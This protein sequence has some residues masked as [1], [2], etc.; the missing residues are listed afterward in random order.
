MRLARLDQWIHAGGGGRVD[1]RIG[2]VVA[3]ASSGEAPGTQDFLRWRWTDGPI[4]RE[5]DLDSALDSPPERAPTNQNR[6]RDDPPGK[7][8]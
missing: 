7:G 1:E 6:W 2:D 8:M 5:Q 3:R 4:K